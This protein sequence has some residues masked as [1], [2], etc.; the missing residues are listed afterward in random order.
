LAEA[1]VR[2]RQGRRA[3][4]PTTGAAAAAAGQVQPD[5]EELERIWLLGLDQGEHLA[6]DD[7]LAGG[8]PLGVALADA[9]GPAQRVRV[10]D[11]PAANQR[12]RLEAA[13]RVLGKAREIRAA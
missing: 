1:A 4:L 9:S 5:L 7:A 13:V 8:Q 10:I 11:E 2:A 3:A 6:L 12:D